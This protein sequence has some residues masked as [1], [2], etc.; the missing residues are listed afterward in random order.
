MPDGQ[1]VIAPRESDNCDSPC[2][3]ATDLHIFDFGHSSDR[4]FTILNDQLPRESLYDARLTSCRS[5]RAV[6]SADNERFYYIVRCG[7]S[8]FSRDLLYST[9]LHGN[10]RLEANFLSAYPDDESAY[11]DAVFPPT[12]K[13][14]L[15]VVTSGQLRYQV[16]E[17][18][19]FYTWRV[20]RVR[21]ADEWEMVAHDTESA[22]F[23]SASKLSPDGRW[24]ALGGNNP[25][26]TLIDV[27]TGRTTFRNGFSN[28]FRLEWVDNMHLLVIESLGDYWSNPMDTWL[29]DITTG[30]RVNLTEDMEG[31]VWIIPTQDTP[32]F[33]LFR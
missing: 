27:A 15:I 20:Y 28:I 18:P 32:S 13:H 2:F 19:D 29:L 9:D 6:W 3:R 4:P 1:R 26:V 10:N 31:R 5:Q 16:R 22:D 21:S 25:Y 14:D 8:S 12:S 30:E 7:Q 23:I 33:T 17:R 24:V 11:I